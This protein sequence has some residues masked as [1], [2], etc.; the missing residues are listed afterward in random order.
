[1][2][3]SSAAVGQQWE[4]EAACGLHSLAPRREIV[5]QSGR[6]AAGIETLN[7]TVKDLRGFGSEERQAPFGIEVADLEGRGARSLAW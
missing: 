2:R 3:F 5:R 1:M 4:L 6:A 7:E